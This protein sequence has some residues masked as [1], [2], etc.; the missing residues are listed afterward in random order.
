MQLS[1]ALNWLKLQRKCLKWCKKQT[2]WIV[3]VVARCLS[4]FLA[5]KM[6]VGQNRQKHQTC[7]RL[8]CQIIDE[9]VSYGQTITEK[10][11]FKI[12]KH[13]LARIKLVRSK[14]SNFE[15]WRLLHHNPSSHSSIIVCQL[16][17]EKE[18]TVL[19]HPPSHL[20][21]FGFSAIS[22]IKNH[23]R[24][25]DFEDVEAIK[26]SV[27]SILS[28]IPYNEFQKPSQRFYGRS[29]ECVAREKKYIES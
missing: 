1:F 11:Y 9:L 13:Q 12:T 29:R 19:E 20:V 14:I 23:F 22:K 27:T 7:E 6:D 15:K 3:W 24:G 8:H 4:D 18:V 5:L 21:S 16:L 2:V 26:I 17:P 25:I 28:G 10:F